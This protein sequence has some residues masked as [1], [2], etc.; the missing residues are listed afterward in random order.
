MHLAVFAP[1]PGALRCTAGL[2]TRSSRPREALAG[3]GCGQG[4]GQKR[5]GAVMRAAA[6]KV[7]AS[8]GLQTGTTS[9]WGGHQAAWLVSFRI[10]MHEAPR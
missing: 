1:G 2:G 6:G 3:Q 9:P 7:E 8:G 4:K 5:G 10:G